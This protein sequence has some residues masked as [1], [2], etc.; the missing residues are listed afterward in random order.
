MAAIRG[1]LSVLSLAQLLQALV[2]NRKAG[3]LTV[4]SGLDRRVLRVG[5]SGLRLV[6]G[7]RRCH[8]FERLLRDARSAPSENTPA[9]FL[10]PAAT[11]RLMA[12]WMLEDISEILSWPGGTF[13]FHPFF[14]PA[15]ELEAGT[16]G[17]YAGDC[18]I[19]R[20]VAQ[21]ERRSEELPRIK[22]AIPDLRHVPVRAGATASPGTGE[23][24]REA[25]DDVLRL[26]DGKRPVITLIHQSVFPR[27]VV[28][29]TLCQLANDGV[30]R[31][32]VPA[33]LALSA[34][35]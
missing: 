3:L 19:P 6:R 16:F 2:Q 15:Q 1:D 33:R 5:T 10:N 25:T 29:R 22:A 17:G 35:A 21:A 26:V 9:P 34:A 11:A 7:S 4:Q 30:I 31:L 8:G 24:D 27:L 32:E 28:L 14:D 18:D 20:A 12:E 23:F 13:E